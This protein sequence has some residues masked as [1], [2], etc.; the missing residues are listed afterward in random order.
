MPP[1]SNELLVAYL[2]SMRS[3]GKSGTEA[4]AAVQ[5]AVEKRQAAP[6]GAGPAGAVPAA[7]PAAATPADIP[8]PAE[9]VLAPALLARLGPLE[10]LGAT[11]EINF[12]L[13][14]PL[15]EQSP[16][17]PQDLASMQFT[18]GTKS[19]Y[20]LSAPCQ[21]GKSPSMVYLS[22]KAVDE[23][24]WVLVILNLNNN[25]AVNS[26]RDKFH[27][28]YDELGILP[29][30]APIISGDI[31]LAGRQDELESQCKLLEDETRRSVWICRA[32][33]DHLGKL[34]KSVPPAAWD[35]CGSQHTLAVPDDV[36]R[37]LLLLWRWAQA[38]VIRQHY[39][40]VFTLRILAKQ[41]HI[42]VEFLAS[43]LQVARK[44]KLF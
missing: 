29:V 9:S 43:L 14:A 24:C 42:H 20:A 41:S 38:L 31:F 2:E 3:D 33:E 12:I 16:F 22:L 25:Q 34:M 18:E 44:I 30:A 8:A 10:R 35:R 37:Y 23:G 4:V 11:K 7:G 19:A 36:M 13:R 15:I 26:L 21:S 28:L 40:C 32:D 1:T 17:L 5:Q 6:A 27:T 39:S